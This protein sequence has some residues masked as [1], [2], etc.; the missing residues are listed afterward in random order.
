MIAYLSGKLFLKK[1]NYCLVALSSGIAYEVF[2]PQEVLF[3]AQ[4]GVKIDLYIHTIVR[5]QEISLYGFLKDEDKDLFRL[6]ISVSG[7]GPKS[8]LEFFTFPSNL[9]IQAIQNQDIAFIN[10]IKGIGKKTAE[11]IILELK[12]KLGEN[13]IKLENQENKN[14]LLQENIFSALENLGFDRRYIIK[15]LK[16]APELKE[17][18]E[19]ITWFLQN[20]QK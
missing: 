7:V 6:L 19:I 16:E 15:I 11:K 9:I 10:N 5:E 13:F 4:I 3:N 12:N 20:H 17:E 18:E 14:Y 2:V 1:S 8:A